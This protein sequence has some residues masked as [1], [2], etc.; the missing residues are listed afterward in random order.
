MDEDDTLPD[1]W[2]VLIN[3]EEQYS[4]WPAG[5]GIP[6]GWRAVRPKASMSDSLNYITQHWIDLRPKSL[7]AD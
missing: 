6:A 3:G 1:D 2:I 4:L 5:T 7:R